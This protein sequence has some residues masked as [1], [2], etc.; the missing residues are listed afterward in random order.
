[1]GGVDLCDMLL[2]L[3]RIHLWSTKYYMNIAFYCIGV[4]VVNGWL[5]YRW[6]TTRKNGPTKDHLSLLKFQTNLAPSLCKAGK[7]CGGATRPRGRPLSTSLVPAD[8]VSKKRKG[9]SVPT[10][11]K[12]SQ[13]DQVGHLPQFQ[14]KTTSPPT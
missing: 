11:T 13:L 14:E 10:L 8:K 5:L 2:S 4:T 6:H 7:V 3:Y 1:M 12:D 9:P